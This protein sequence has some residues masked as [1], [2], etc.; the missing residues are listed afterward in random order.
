MN[1]KSFAAKFTQP[2]KPQSFEIIDKIEDKSTFSS[3][4]QFAQSEIIFKLVL[5]IKNQKV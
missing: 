3:S 2:F 1:V 4:Y 5:L